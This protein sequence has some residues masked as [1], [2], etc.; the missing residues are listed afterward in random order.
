MHMQN[1]TV[2]NL[3]LFYLTNVVKLTCLNLGCFVPE[4]PSPVLTG[5]LQNVDFNVKYLKL[6]DKGWY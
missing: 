2:Y 1:I 5:N 6:S 3:L 4:L